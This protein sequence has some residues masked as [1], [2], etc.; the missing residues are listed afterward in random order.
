MQ[1]IGHVNYLTALL[2]S[3]LSVVRTGNFQFTP[4]TFIFGTTNGITYAIGF[5]L[6]TL[7]LRLSGVVVTFAVVRLS[8]VVPIVVAMLFW[9]ETPN[10]WQSIG[11][12]LACSALPLLG[13]KSKSKPAEEAVPEQKS[14]EQFPVS[15]P[16]EPVQRLGIL[17]V[18][19]LFINS[20]ISRLAMKAFNELCPIEQ[21]PVY[22]VFL[23][24]VTSA[25]YT[26]AAIY[27][28]TIPTL[29]EGFYGVLIGICNV[30]GSW[31]FLAALDR[32]DAL[33]AFPVSGSGGVLFTTLVGVLFIGERLD[34]R[35]TVGVII[36][37]VA[38]I[39]VNLQRA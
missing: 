31:A 39:L 32:V 14:A 19:S 3:I 2:I 30:M 5:V 36:T 9:H 4:L 25:V 1:P 27:Q 6:V 8:L 29:W 24:T 11:I 13:T 7:G 20:G 10:L 35:S 16:P 34:R 22:L 15:R 12:L 26:V 17:I 37:I 28:R 18:A 23:F 33:I 21:K 38:L